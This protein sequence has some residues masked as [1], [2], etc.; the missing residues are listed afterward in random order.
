MTAMPPRPAPSSQ[1]AC[2]TPARNI[3]G[4]CAANVR[5]QQLNNAIA[6]GTQNA[7]QVS[8]CWEPAIGIKPTMIPFTGTAP[9]LNAML[10]GEVDYE[11]DPVLGTLSQVQAGNV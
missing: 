9:V 6:I 7:A 8:R 11:C 4:E 3:F 2:A 1:P 10:G 5:L